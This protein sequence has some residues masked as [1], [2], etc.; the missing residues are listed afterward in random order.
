MRK[1]STVL[2]A[3]ES[4]SNSLR[5]EVRGDGVTTYKMTIES[6]KDK[7]K[8]HCSCPQ[9]N[10][11][12][13]CKHCLGVLNDELWRVSGDM[14]EKVRD[15]L[16]GVNIE[17]LNDILSELDD[18]DDKIEKLQEQIDELKQKKP[19]IKAKAAQLAGVEGLPRSMPETKT[20]AAEPLPMLRLLGLDQGGAQ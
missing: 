20:R 15:I 14:F 5:F 4:N 19:E 10:Q 7:L 3:N 6:D 16:I 11:G 1:K 9:G 17:P 13:I 12:Y 18:I 8:I 2:P